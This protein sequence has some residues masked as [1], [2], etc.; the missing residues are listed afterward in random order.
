MQDLRTK[1]SAHPD[2]AIG[3]LLDSVSKSHAGRG[4]ALIDE[5]GRMLAG[6]G[7]PSE[8]WSVVRAA[9]RK[10]Q[11]EGFVTMPVMGTPERL[12]LASF[13]VS[14]MQRVAVGVARIL[15]GL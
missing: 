4:I 5:R 8:M 13:G 12:R 2:L 9:Q 7:A 10:T 3:Y 1:R 15:R 14:G 6:S 11:S